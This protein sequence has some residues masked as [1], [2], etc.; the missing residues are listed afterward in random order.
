M[1]KLGLVMVQIHPF[2]GVIYFSMVFWYDV[3]ICIALSSFSPQSHAHSGKQHTYYHTLPYHILSTMMVSI[4]QPWRKNLFNSDNNSEVVWVKALYSFSTL[5]FIIN[6]YF[7]KL[8]DTK[9]G[10]TKV[11]VLEV[12]FISSRSFSQYK[13]L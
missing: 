9:F 4:F 1:I 3:I 10:P 11:H 8:Q 12:D 6:K 5:E 13:S 2:L 7:L